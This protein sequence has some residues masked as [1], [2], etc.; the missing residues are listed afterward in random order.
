MTKTSIKLLTLFLIFSSC[1]K[2]E[3]VINTRQLISQYN[4][5][6]FGSFNPDGKRN[7]N[8]WLSRDSTL[9]F[10]LYE[11]RKTNHFL[12]LVQ[13]NMM[14]TVY[15]HFDSTRFELTIRDFFKTK[16]NYFVTLWTPPLNHYIGYP[17]DYNFKD[18]P[19]KDLYTYNSLNIFHIDS[20]SHQ[21][22]RIKK[23]SIEYVAEYFKNHFN[24]EGN[25]Y[26]VYPQLDGISR[27]DNNK[28]EGFITI[29]KDT[30]NNYQSYYQSNVKFEP[31][32]T[33]KYFEL[34]PKLSN[35][36]YIGLFK[37]NIGYWEEDIGN[38]K[39]ASIKYKY[40]Y[41]YLDPVDNSY[42]GYQKLNKIEFISYYDNK[43]YVISTLKEKDFFG[44]NSEKEIEKNVGL[45]S[46]FRPYIF[47]HLNDGYFITTFLPSQNDFN[48]S[49]P[50]I[51]H[52][53]TLQWKLNK[54]ELFDPL[55][56]KKYTR[57]QR[58]IPIGLTGR[59]WDISHF[60]ESFEIV[61]VKDGYRLIEK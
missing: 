60:F 26:I 27:L 20:I 59:M 16:E 13:N 48:E 49:F 32:K 1:K 36:N 15:K 25:Y 7:E 14:D 33:D 12:Y 50:P 37:D 42:S 46:E 52:L 51:F 40:Y 41:Y 10:T 39:E 35:I 38:T 18:Y 6:S 24:L 9:I 22:K 8:K 5:E 21:I 43:E 11:N 28:N 55:I 34:K 2:E 45:V 3:A 30:L 31:H 44:L 54:V 17:S 58:K 61:K 4:L 47:K 23:P 19:Y 29:A 53:D 56:D 57:L